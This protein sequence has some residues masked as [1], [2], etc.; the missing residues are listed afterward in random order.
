MRPSSSRTISTIRRAVAIPI[1]DLLHHALKEIRILED[2][3]LADPNDIHGLLEAAV[4]RA[5]SFCPRDELADFDANVARLYES[6]RMHKTVE[7]LHRAGT[8]LDEEPVEPQ[9]ESE[10]LDAL[11]KKAAEARAQAAKKAEEEFPS[12]RLGVL[13]RAVAAERHPVD[14]LAPSGRAQSSE[15]VEAVETRRLGRRRAPAFPA[16]LSGGPGPPRGF[17]NRPV[18]DLRGAGLHVLRL[19][20]LEAH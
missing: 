16:V 20:A 3:R 8:D 1:S 10:G 4:R 7:L 2:L 18:S 12:W 19:V 14:P 9:E 15:C 17:R 5:R 6:S 13:G 11:R